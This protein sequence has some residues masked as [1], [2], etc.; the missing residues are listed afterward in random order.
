MKKAIALMLILCMAVSFAACGTENKPADGTSS[1]SVKHEVAGEIAGEISISCYDTM[2]YKAFLEAAANL[3]MA[4][5]PGT[6]VTIKTFSTMPEVKVMEKDGATVM[7]SEITDDPV[8]RADYLSKLNTELIGGGGAD[9]LALDILPIERYAK[10]GQFAPLDEFMNSDPDFHPEDYRQ[11]I[12]EAVKQG[13][14]TVFL[15]TDYSFNYATFDKSLFT[16]EQAETLKN[17][18]T[19]TYA[20]LISSAEGAF[21]SANA[22][23]DKKIRMLE[24]SA[25]F[26]FGALWDEN[27]SKFINFADRTANFTD[28]SFAALL[29]AVKGYADKGYIF[30]DENAEIISGQQVFFRVKSDMSLAYDLDYNKVSPIQFFDGGSEND[31]IGGIQANADGNIPFRFFRGY[32]MNANSKN[33]R[34]AWE[35]LKFLLSEEM[36]LSVDGMGLPIN[37]AARAKKAE[38]SIDGSLYGEKTPMTE[39]MQNLLAEYQAAVERFSD[40]INAYPLADSTISAMIREETAH[41]FD[42]AK[43]ASEV[44]EALQS[45]V[46]LY[47][48][49]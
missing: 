46:N 28:G 47:L 29:E 36:Q 35:F 14:H 19:F 25:R 7:S 10:N 32:A 23:A 49:E 21:A 9:L 4:K 16:P 12:L 24:Q 11:N 20:G 42:G 6:K 43:T 13:G 37:N 26:L 31:I 30:S 2:Q 22:G 40:R 5:Y 48:G 33:Q 41:F 17:E 3:F 44:C 38:M 1:A 39:G 15:P 27:Y 18:G 8:A 45:R 34:T